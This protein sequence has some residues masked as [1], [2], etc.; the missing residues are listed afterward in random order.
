M[1]ETGSTPD[2]DVI[3]DTMAPV[4][5]NMEKLSAKD[6]EAIAA[7]LKTLPSRPN[8]VQ[9]SKTNADDEDDQS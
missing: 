2:F 3:G 9:K 1:L 5:E 4:Q 6:R 7:F 8:A